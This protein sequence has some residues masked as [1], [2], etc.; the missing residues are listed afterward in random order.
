VPSVHL[1]GEVD[2]A[3]RPEP[4]AVRAMLSMPLAY[5]S[6]LDRRNSASYV[7]ELWSPALV[8][9]REMCRQK[10]MLIQ[11]LLFPALA[12]Q[13]AFLSQA[14]PRV[15]SV[16]FKLSIILSVFGNDEGDPLGSPS[17]KLLCG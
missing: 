9:F 2:A 3:A 11:Q 8:R 1:V 13:R 12:A 7:E 14:G 6:T 15:R 4:V 10:Q 17:L 16:A 5:P